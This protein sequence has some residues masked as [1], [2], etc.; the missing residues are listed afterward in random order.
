MCVTAKEG[1][2]FFQRLELVKKNHH[3]DIYVNIKDN[4]GK[5]PIDIASNS[6]FNGNEEII[7]LPLQKGVTG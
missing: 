2:L 3:K 4:G 6:V 5:T 1:L 7:S